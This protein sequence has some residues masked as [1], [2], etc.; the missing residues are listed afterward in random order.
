MAHKNI[1]AVVRAF[2][3]LPHERLVVAGDGPELDRL[4]N[5]GGRNVRILGHVDDAQLRW[6]FANARGLVAASREDFGLTPLEAASFGLPS[7]L[8]RFGGFLDTMVEDETATFFDEPVPAQV[9]DAVRRLGTTRWS[10]E[11]IQQNAARFSE[12][13]FVRRLREIVAEESRA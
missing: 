10:T 8:L 9:A 7:A 6:L 11:R 2:E 5:L 1:D 12:D 4:R 3:A 13:R